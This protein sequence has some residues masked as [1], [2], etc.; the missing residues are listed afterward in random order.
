MVSE[1]QI[2]FQKTKYDNKKL[3]LVIHFV[4]NVNVQPYHTKPNMISK[5]PDMVPTTHIWF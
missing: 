4:Q 1:N 5:K 3:N 2:W